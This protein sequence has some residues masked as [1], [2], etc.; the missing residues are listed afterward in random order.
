MAIRE[1]E[2]V[3]GRH[4]PIIA[5]TASAMESDREHCMAAG[6]DDYLSK[7]IK[8]K[9]LAE[10]LERWI[11]GPTEASR[12]SDERADSALLQLSGAVGAPG[13]REER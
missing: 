11:P 7:P 4:V 10:M 12:S 9:E 6:M 5:L 8:P 1:A 13:S 3:T 2:L